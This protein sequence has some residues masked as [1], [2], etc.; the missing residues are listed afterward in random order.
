MRLANP[1]KTNPFKRNTSEKQKG[2]KV[3]NI[4]P[5]DVE[6]IVET[7]WVREPYAK[8]KIGVRTQSEKSLFYIVEEMQLDEI[9]IDA[10]KRLASL[11]EKEIRPPKSADMDQSKYVMEEAARLSKRYSR[12][13]K[14]VT[15]AGW[16]K[17]FHYIDRN[18][19]GYGD[20]D[21]L[22]GDPRIEDISCNGVDRAIYVWHQQY[23]GIPT[24]VVFKEE[25]DYNNLIIKLAHMSGKHI[26]SAYPVLDAMLPEKHRLAATFM[27]EVSSFGSSFTIRKFREKPFS[28]VDLIKLGTI[29]AELAAYFWLLLENK[30]S[31]MIIGG[32]GAGKTSMLNALGSLLLPNDKI[33][34]VEEVNEL[35]LY[36]ENWVQLVSR[37]GFKFGASDSNAISLFDLVKLSLRY[38]P[39]YIVVGEVR[40]EEAYVLFQAMAT[41]H[42]GL[43]TMHADSLDH[44]IKRL[45]S[46]PMNVSEIYI[47]L[48]NVCIYTSRSEIPGKEGDRDFG[49]RIRTVSEV[50]DFDNLRIISDWSPIS[51]SFETTVNES[52]LLERLAQVKGLTKNDLLEDI[53]NRT[54][55]LNGLVATDTTDQIEISK[56]LRN[57]S[58]KVEAKKEWY[59]FSANVPINIQF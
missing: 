25:A 43:C 50:L 29:D 21:T 24:N 16:E 30:M 40:G 4:I 34:T 23:E 20:L 18:M 48:M 1:F 54:A 31:I 27:R 58:Q 39:E 55:V 53:K 49:R 14:Q 42:G 12:S 57:Y 22:I 10:Y 56:A 19:V 46:P 51:D 6:D 15:P 36:H 47:P 5:V 37:R 26:S 13:F 45:T 44:A 59:S 17:V 52:I 7:Y 33:V 2:E 32:T 11:L 9:E 35:N 41:G 3:A 38:R 28:I 8:V